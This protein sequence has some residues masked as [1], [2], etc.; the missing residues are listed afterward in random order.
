MIDPIKVDNLS[1][2]I[3]NLAR[4]TEP[5][6]FLR[7]LVQNSIESIQRSGRRTGKITIDDE[8]VDGY[9][10]WR[11][12]DNGEG[13]TGEEVNQYVNRFSASG[14]GQSFEENYGIGAKI[15][16]LAQSPYGLIY[17]C[18]K[19][20]QG[21]LTHLGRDEHGNYGRL[22]IPRAGGEGGVIY[23]SPLPLVA[24]KP[25]PIK[26]DGVS[27][28]LLGESKEAEPLVTAAE[29]RSYLNRRYFEF[30]S[31]IEVRI[32]FVHEA[33]QYGIAFHRVFGQHYHLDKHS[34]SKGQVELNDSTV[35]WW[36][37][38][39]NIRSFSS[40]WLHTGHIGTIY[41]NELY[42]I[43]GERT[44]RRHALKA[45][46][47]YA[48]QSKIVIYIEPH[49]VLKPNTAR[50]DLIMEDDQSFSIAQIGAL[51]AA[52]MPK[53]LKEYMDNQVMDISANRQTM[54]RRLR[55]LLKNW[56]T[57]S[58]SNDGEFNRCT[59]T[60]GGQ[61]ATSITK[62]KPSNDD[63]SHPQT[64]GR[65]GNKYLRLTQEGQ[66]QQTKPTRPDLFPNI[67]WDD[68][69]EVVAA[70]RAASYTPAAHKLV[71]NKQYSG[72]KN[73]VAGALSMVK[74]RAP[75]MGDNTIQ[76]MAEP[77]ARNWF[78][79]SLCEAVISLR[80]LEHDAKWG[81]EVFDTALS[82]EGL[83][84]AVESHKW[85]LL[86]CIERDV[87]RTLGTPKSEAEEEPE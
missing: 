32:E 78:E 55:D 57:F 85:H 43:P 2:L 13:M 84:A 47:I 6:Q 41:K 68:T 11:I 12:S 22:A 8:L 48:G 15:T 54:Q 76:Q 63:G 44:E 72:Y 9:P 31:N 60:Q 81:P 79:Q 7:E 3:K 19:H 74:A 30:P 61:I 73:L 87:T 4:D 23:S 82:D 26:K 16:A 71:I 58:K 34:Q 49:N 1:R 53:S 62:K 29:A 40:E 64:G 75:H 38:K 20:G 36:I 46:G 59:T 50:T 24:D 5:L 83:T 65:L 27:V 21:T 69:G 10:K 28:V 52:Q 45:F 77:I 17:K 66:S 25:K 33:G 70:E 67:A 51:F 37:I 14:A 42:N 18:W 39:E 35:W 56:S 80:P 86:K